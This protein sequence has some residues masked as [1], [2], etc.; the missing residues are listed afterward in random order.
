MVQNFISS[1]KKNNVHE[2]K[3]S[4]NTCINIRR[5]ESDSEDMV[6]KAQNSW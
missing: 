3:N 4:M 5:E 1:H 2:Q 6:T